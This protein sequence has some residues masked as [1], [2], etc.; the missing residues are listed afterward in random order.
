[1]TEEKRLPVIQVALDFLELDRAVS[2]AREAAAGGAARLEAGTPLIK[3]EGLNAV[4]RLRAE[5]PDRTIVADLK[6]MDAGRI[7][8]EA[9]A[10][11]GA[12]IAV[13]LGAASESTIRECVE[14]GRNYGIEVAVDVLGAADAVARAKEAQAWGASEVWVHVPID[15]QM[16]GREAFETLREVAGAVS[17]PVAVAGGLHPGNVV[18]AAAAGADVLI[19]GGAITKS[20]DAQ[21]ATRAVLNALRTGK[22]EATHLYRRGGEGDIRSILEKVSAA[23]LS[24]A[25]HRGGVAEGLRPLAP[26]TRLV[27][28]A[29]TVRTVA[30]DW[31]KPVEAI[32]VASSGDVLV[33][34]AGGRPPAVWGELATTSALGRGLAG[35]VVDGAVRD[36]ADVRASGF[37]VFTRHVSPNAGE[38]KGLGEIG[39]PVT[40]GGQRVLPGDWILGDDDGVVVLPR[41]RAVEYANRAMDVLE[42][43]NRIR[44]EIRAGSTLSKV[45]ELLRW[46]KRG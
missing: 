17:V 9:A 38:P 24:D 35:L 29:V 30:G 16:R 42:R 33:V 27:G 22:A 37:A 26:G 8:M 2:C 14:V 34:D 15:D 5:F 10:K 7:E 3:S 41:D 25:L 21:E 31:A 20:V 39:A 6:T 43:E 23:N 1:V 4:R 40:V 46:E 45:V 28:T 32:D 11:A 44:A 12:K 13:V 19:V 18:E 36:T